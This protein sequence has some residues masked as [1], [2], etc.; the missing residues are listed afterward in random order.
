MK[1][2]N[3]NVSNDVLDSKLL[4]SSFQATFWKISEISRPKNIHL[5]PPNSQIL[6]LICQL[7]FRISSANTELSKI[8]QKIEF[9]FFFEF[10]KNQPQKFLNA[11]LIHLQ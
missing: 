9:E 3:I 2:R 6:G 1:I 11:L 5:L 8:N 7:T 4:L 10:A